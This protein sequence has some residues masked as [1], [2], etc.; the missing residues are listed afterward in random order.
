MRDIA[1]SPIAPPN[2]T[3]LADVKGLLGISD[4]SSDARLTALIGA[5]SQQVED[6]CGRILSSRSVTE[7]SFSDDSLDFY[8]VDHIPVIAVSSISV[9]G[10]PLALTDIIVLKSAGIVRMIDGSPIA[11]PGQ[12]I[13]VEYQAGFS[14]VPSSVSDAALSLVK[15]LYGSQARDAAVKRESVPDVG[16]VEYFES[17]GPNGTSLPAD[18]AAPLSSYVKWY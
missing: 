3:T 16:E 17:Q 10:S 6:Y 14:T 13:E 8:V 9:D 18:I 2:M 15:H 5:A 4:S 11:G 7:T 1:I 12:K